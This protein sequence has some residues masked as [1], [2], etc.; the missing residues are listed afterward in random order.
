MKCPFIIE[1]MPEQLEG[2]DDSVLLS[3]ELFLH[4]LGLF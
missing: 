3:H 4:D 1:P 2:A